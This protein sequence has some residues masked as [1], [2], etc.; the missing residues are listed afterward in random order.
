[1]EVLWIDGHNLK[2]RDV[3]EVARGRRRVR[4]TPEALRLTA[5]CRSVVDLLVEHNVPVYGLTTGFGSK[6]GRAHV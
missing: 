6:I 4:I 1:M 3:I 5:R 2:L